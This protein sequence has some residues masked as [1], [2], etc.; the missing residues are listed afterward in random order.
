MRRV[1]PWLAL[2]LVAS[3]AAAEPRGLV[4][5]EGG[6]LVSPASSGRRDVAPL[7][8]LTATLSF[9]L[10]SR[11]TF[12]AGLSSIP[13]PHLFQVGVPVRFDV[14]ATGRA[15]DGLLV[16]LGARPLLVPVGVCVLG[17]RSH[18]QDAPEGSRTAGWGLGGVAEVGLATRLSTKASFDDVQ[19]LE[20]SISG[21]A[22]PL[23]TFAGSDDRPITGLYVGGIAS[24]GGMF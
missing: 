16:R 6:A 1:L 9:P 7:T 13:Y 11:V 24:V 4:Q 21:L 3:T 8:V 22:G 14:L 15:E 10:T 18:C 5:L 23:A 17:G 2:S 12:A 20:L 19:A